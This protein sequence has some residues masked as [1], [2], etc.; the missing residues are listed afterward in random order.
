MSEL[1]A[2]LLAQMLPVCEENADEIGQALMRGI[3][4]EVAVAVGKGDTYDDGSPPEGFDGDGLMFKMQFGDVAMAGVLTETSG[5]LRG[6][7]REPDVT[8]EG[9]LNTLAQELSMLVVPDTMMSE[10]FGASI[11]DNIAQT[12]RE[13]ELAD[14]ANVLTLDLT[15]G[16]E[17]SQ[18]WLLWPC[19]EPSKLLPPPKPKPEPKVEVSS[20][21]APPPP[22]PKPSTMQEL[23]P[24]ARHLLKISVPVSV[25]LVSKRLT[26]QEVL[27]MGPG[28]MVS[29]DKSC[30]DTL[31]LLVGDRTIARGSAVK[32]G[33]RFGLEIE[34]MTLP[35]E[36]FFTAR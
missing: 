14:D 27:E 4:A 32:V 20:E 23:P 34:E 30:D 2:D 18:L 1:N 28:A 24:Y 10:K 22:P 8:G 35:E 7:M 9:M 17:T 11:V 25:R 21:P 36:H 3:D 12:L 33:E 6:W 31:E 15:S 16:S 29:F 19:A 5:L 26:V 13:A